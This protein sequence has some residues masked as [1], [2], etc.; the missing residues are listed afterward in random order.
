MQETEMLDDHDVKPLII[1]TSTPAAMSDTVTTSEP[2]HTD[3]DA[4]KSD[5]LPS[6][7]ESS[8]IL[9]LAP[10]ASCS[11]LSNEVDDPGEFEE[12]SEPQHDGSLSNDSQSTVGS[13]SKGDVSGSGST[14]DMSPGPGSTV[15]CS[16]SRR[17]SDRVR[18]TIVLYYYICP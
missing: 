9:P 13:A 12:G 1:D 4:T 16:K 18:T 11:E 2:D 10:V 6:R 14:G 15:G 17:K 8:P 7:S 5:E 3:P